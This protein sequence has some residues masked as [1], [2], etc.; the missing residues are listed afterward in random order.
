MDD[1]R[2]KQPAAV[3]TLDA[4]YLY[5]VEYIDLPAKA[6]RRPWPP[7]S[8]AEACSNEKNLV[9]ENMKDA[10]DHLRRLLQEE[11]AAHEALAA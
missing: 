4:L 3:N 8:K 1:S 10:L 11:R 2:H 9:L 7:A 6:A 5:F